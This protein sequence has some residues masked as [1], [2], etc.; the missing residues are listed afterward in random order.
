MNRRT[1][2][3]LN[4]LG[5][6]SFCNAYANHINHFGMHHE[7]MNV[8]DSILNID[9]SFINF[10]SNNLKLLDEKY[11][12]QNQNLKA[13]PLLKN[14]SKTK[15]TFKA[16]LQITQSQLEIVK[17]KKTKVYTY[18]GTIP[19]PKIEVFEGDN[20]EI[21]VKNRL[22]EPTTIHWH[23]L[24]VAPEQDGN[25]HDHILAGEERVYRFNLPMG[26]AGTY[27]YHPHP[28]HIASKQVFMGLAGAFVVK[29]KQDV[30]SDLV[31]KDLMISDLRLDEN[32]QIPNNNLTDWLNGR[33]GEF[34][35]INGQYKPKI[36]L[37]TNE[38]IRIYNATSARYL[39]LK[40]HGA[41]FI[42]VGTDGGLI[43]KPIYKDEIFLTP[44]SRVEVLIQS[45]KS[46]EFKL[47]SLYYNRD[48]M[49]VQ[50]EPKTLFLADIILENKDISIPDKLRELPRLEEPKSFKEIIMSENHS[51]MMQIMNSKDD[52][53]IK[54]ALASMFL[55]NSK[56]YDLNRTDLISEV[57]VVE[58]WVVNNNSHMDHP[59]HI[60]G[61]QFEVISSKL[62]NVVSKPEFRAL[63]DTINVRP[64]E[65]I[66]LRMK[67]DFV[68]TRMF[69]CH[70]LEHEDLGM[71][72]N[73]EVKEYHLKH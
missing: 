4:A 21:L 28:H 25:P 27:W 50:E 62:N 45:S 33:E 35:L 73:L 57:G 31:E 8:N 68:G 7:M 58:E 34:I 71:M 39:R 42:L 3:K 2:L 52:N 32:A 55:M 43:Q 26:S 6:V 49:M 53:E 38:R 30:L 65:E 51:K 14:E 29:S 69:H 44:A 67:Q 12:P 1:F 56:T 63:R 60:H 36:R 64:N 10:S 11:F 48:K 46:G 66:R 54:A 13:L 5:L 19:A 17:G 47:E 59:F 40:I 37:V 41:N 20:V 72:G 16:T 70:I 9:T 18:N 23:G 24:L 22:S 15:N 61:T